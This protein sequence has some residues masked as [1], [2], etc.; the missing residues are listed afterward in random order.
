MAHK[1]EG[2]HLVDT[3]DLSNPALHGCLAH[4]VQPA[5]ESIVRAVIGMHEAL[6]KQGSCEEALP[7]WRQGD[8]LR[9]RECCAFKRQLT[10][11]M[12]SC[13]HSMFMSSAKNLPTQTLSSA[14]G[15]LGQTQ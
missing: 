11:G 8:N 1:D 15:R 3:L 6:Y 10:F 13:G 2:L 14:A 12:L 7:C 9:A 5:N 4:A